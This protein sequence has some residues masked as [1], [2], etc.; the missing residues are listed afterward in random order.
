M[1]LSP[2]LAAAFLVA[3]SLAAHADPI[4]AGTY[5]GALLATTTG[6]IAGTGKTISYTESVYQEAGTGFLEFVLQ[7]DNSS[8]DYYIN[9]VSGADFSGYT[10][11]F[12]YDNDGN[13]SNVAPDSVSENKS[14]KVTFDF[15]D[16]VYDA[17]TDSLIIY[18]DATNYTTGTVAISDGQTIDPPGFEPTG[19]VAPA[20]TPEPSS[21]LLLGTGLIG[22][23]GVVRRRLA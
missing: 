22:M 9:S 21:L 10:T 3:G 6:T 11:G 17:N 5:S 18:T 16:G 23:A 8:Y 1:R 2:L 7:A 15:G 4:A 19:G 13:A 14:G 20:P 12:A